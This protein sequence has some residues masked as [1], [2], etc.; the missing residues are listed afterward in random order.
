V[1]N[2]IA[3]STKCEFQN[4]FCTQLNNILD[5]HLGPKFFIVAN[6]LTVLRYRKCHTA[7]RNVTFI[8]TYNFMIKITTERDRERR[9]RKGQ[10]RKIDKRKISSNKQYIERRK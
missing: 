6:D 1:L 3:D 9:G 8:L 7:R 4:F 10:K 5:L 2:S